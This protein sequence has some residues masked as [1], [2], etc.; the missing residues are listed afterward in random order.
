LFPRNELALCQFVEASFSWRVLRSNR[1]LY[2]M[3]PASALQSIAH[4]M[5]PISCPHCGQQFFDPG[6]VW[7]LP[8]QITLPKPGTTLRFVVSCANCAKWIVFAITNGALA[9]QP[10]GTK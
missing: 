9:A 3:S 8:G 2:C 1:Y 6:K 7:N 4:I 5:R 10:P